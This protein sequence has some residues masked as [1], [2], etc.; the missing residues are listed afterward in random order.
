MAAN[1]HTSLT[2]LGVTALGG[3]V[4]TDY[5][6]QIRIG[7]GTPAHTG[8][9][10]E[11]YVEGAAEIL[12][13]L[14]LTGTAIENDAALF[15]VIP[16]NTATAWRIGT[17]GEAWLTLRTSTATEKVQVAKI[18][19]TSTKG[20]FNEAGGTGTT[21]QPERFEVA[22]VA[23]DAAGG[24]VNFV[25]PWGVEC[26]VNIKINVKVK[27]TGACT[28]DVGVAATGVSDDSLI[29]GLDVGTA[30]GVRTNQNEAWNTTP[31]SD[32]AATDVILG[33]VQYVTI[34]MKTGAAAGLVGDAFITLEPT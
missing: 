2:L 6:E 17:D 29:D 14:W 15:W 18:L 9:V 1:Q 3:T 34:S 23:S 20:W 19:E 11:L 4:G 21:R 8:A 31:N 26:L 24:I 28:V 25:N 30:I 7:N 16:D 32:A 33:A 5:F 10:D 22:L 27:T 12:G 13:K